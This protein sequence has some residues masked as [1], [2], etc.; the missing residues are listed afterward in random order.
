MQ[1]ELLTKRRTKLSP[2]LEDAMLRHLGGIANENGYFWDKTPTQLTEQFMMKQTRRWFKTFDYINQFRGSANY[3]SGAVDWLFENRRTDGL[4]DWGPQTKDP[5]G[6]F[7][8]HSC[9]R[10]YSHNRVVDC[11][12]QILH[13]LKQYI[14]VN[15]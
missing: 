10:N 15:T 2:K 5:W 9:N 7:G 11:T 1:S 3:L 12:M 4:W 6:Y 8:Y 14:E 13:F